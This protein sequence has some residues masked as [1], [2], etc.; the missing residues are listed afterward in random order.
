M[1]VFENFDFF[2]KQ[3]DG[4]DNAKKLFKMLKKF[5]ENIIFSFSMIFVTSSA[6]D[7]PL[8]KIFIS[9]PTDKVLKMC[10][11]DVILEKMVNLKG[12]QDLL[13]FDRSLLKEFSSEI[14]QVFNLVT[15]KFDEI[16][17]IAEKLLEYKLE[18]FL[19]QYKRAKIEIEKMG[20][21][22]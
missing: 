4:P 14:V 20:L 2:L 22:S 16:T 6:C 19:N 15:R 11:M 5:K 3:R 17:A 9:Y 7:L 21:D 12:M 10:V 18:P 1:I 8:P 13:A